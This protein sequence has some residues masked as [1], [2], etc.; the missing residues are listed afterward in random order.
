VAKKC[1]R[2]LATLNASLSTTST[3]PRQVMGKSYFTYGV[4]TGN[5]KKAMYEHHQHYRFDLNKTHEKQ[6]PTNKSNEA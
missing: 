6:K 1:W 5:R 2:L 3:T 4:E